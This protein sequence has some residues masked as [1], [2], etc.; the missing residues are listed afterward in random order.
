MLKG[1]TTWYASWYFFDIINT[2]AKFWIWYIPKHEDLKANI[3]AQQASGFGVGGCKFHIKEKLMQEI[4]LFYMQEQQN[5][6]SRVAE[7]A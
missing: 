1:V 2:F 6:L 4:H 5:R 3:L 7:S